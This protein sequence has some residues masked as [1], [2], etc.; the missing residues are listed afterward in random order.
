M[1]CCSKHEEEAKQSRE[2]FVAKRKISNKFDLENN[3]RRADGDGTGYIP[4]DVLGVIA[5]ETTKYCFHSQ[6]SEV[7]HIYISSL[8]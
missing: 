6:I 5:Q 8:S 4:R 7:I 2:L 3:L 1:Y